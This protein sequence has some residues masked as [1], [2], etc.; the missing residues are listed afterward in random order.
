MAKKRRL[1]ASVDEGL[2]R[3]YDDLADESEKVRLKAAGDLVSKYA[4]DKNPSAQKLADV[5]R[6]LFR[7]LSSGRKAARPGFSVALTEFLSSHRL[8]KACQDDDGALN[9]ETVIDALEEH[10]KAFGKAPVSRSSLSPYAGSRL[11]RYRKKRIAILVEY[12]APRPLSSLRRSSL[13][14]RPTLGN[15]LGS[16]GLSLMLSTTRLG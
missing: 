5:L 6:R 10:T 11:I 3:V 8:S 12:S 4:P 15:G 7:G 14:C 9:P 2:V 13:V 1:N 16:C